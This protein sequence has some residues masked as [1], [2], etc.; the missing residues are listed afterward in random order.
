MARSFLTPKGLRIRLTVA[1]SPSHHQTS[2][3]PSPNKLDAGLR[4]E[5]SLRPDKVDAPAN[6]LRAKLMP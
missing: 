3:K 4:A 1:I 6:E 5:L 2:R